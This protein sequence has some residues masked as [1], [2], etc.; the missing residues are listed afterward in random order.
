MA[1]ENPPDDTYLY[2]TTTGRKSGQPRHIEIWFV[3]HGGCYYM[4][5]E[6]R[7][8]AHWVRNIL[9]NPAVTFSVGR[10]A[11]REETRPLAA[12]RGRTI[13]PAAEPA[14]AAAVSAL[15]DAKYGWSDGLIVELR[16]I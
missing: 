9:H 11:A 8:N 10:R 2:L 14:L 4:V 3:E 16:P 1:N 12:A 5:A 13:R 7:E 15:M 6:G